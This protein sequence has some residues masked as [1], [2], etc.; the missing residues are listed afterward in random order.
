[1]NIKGKTLLVTGGAGFVGSHIVDYALAAGEKKV[2]V[3][4]NFLRGSRANLAHLTGEKR[5]ELVEGDIRDR[6]LV[7][8]LT[9]GVD[10]VCHQAAV[11]LLKCAEDPRLCHEV[12]VDGTFNVLEAAVEHKVE[13]VVMASSVSVYGEPSYVPMGES[14]PYNNTTMYGAAKIANEHLAT[15]FHHMYKLPIIMF[16][17]FNVYGPRM[18]IFGAYTE[19]LIKWLDRLD[20]GE[21]PIIDGDGKQALDFVYVEDV[22]AAN[23][24]AFAS[25]VAFGIYNV[26]TGKLTSLRELAQLLIK[27]TGSDIKPLFRSDVT[28]PYVQKRQADI[29][30]AREELDFTA[31]TL[32]ENGLKKLIE[33]RK[34]RLKLHRHESKTEQ[35]T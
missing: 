26:G 22:A 8:K 3:L 1:M 33:W 24:A 14:H 21:A 23:V 13:K 18:D 4:D 5:L 16:R 19:V 35:S 6:E 28:R 31:A 12:M 7:Q 29:T 34:E 20:K 17:Y 32:I 27:S 10:A 11:R 9:H 15:A 2:I 30:K 25:G